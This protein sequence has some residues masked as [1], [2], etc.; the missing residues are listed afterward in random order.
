ML[1]NEPFL[2]SL[3]SFASLQDQQQLD[4]WVELVRK[5]QWKT[6]ISVSVWRLEKEGGQYIREHEPFPVPLSYTATRR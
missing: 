5:G 1:E 2:C 4:F 6:E 3:S